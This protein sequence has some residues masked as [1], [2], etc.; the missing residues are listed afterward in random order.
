MAFEDAMTIISYASPYPVTL[1]IQ[2]LNSLKPALQTFRSSRR[3][4]SDRKAQFH[5][6]IKSQSSED[7][8]LN[9]NFY[10]MN[11]LERTSKSIHLSNTKTTQL[12]KEKTLTTVPPLEVVAE[13]REPL[14]KMLMKTL[15]ECNNSESSLESL[16]NTT[17]TRNVVVTA[18]ISQPPKFSN[19]MDIVI[20]PA[21]AKTKGKAPF[22]AT[23]DNE[24]SPE[25]EYNDLSYEEK[26]QVIRL[27]YE[28]PEKSQSTP[29]LSRPSSDTEEI[30][31][32]QN[33]FQDSHSKLACSKNLNL[34]IRK[35]NSPKKFTYATI[36]VNSNENHQSNLSNASSNENMSEFNKEQYE[37]LVYFQSQLAR[38][39]E[40]LAKLG[41]N[42]PIPTNN[43]TYAGKPDKRKINVG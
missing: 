3:Y 18:E 28:D 16:D 32:K 43:A 8:G 4:S 22:T 11:T 14:N 13:K 23:N 34:D 35:P 12:E 9:N 25:P 36:D 27:S 42:I 10:Q 15:S 21:R 33:Y 41:I 40:E 31:K 20:P 1:E 7:I 17:S 29:N 26:L 2:K 5:P 24:K 6:L 38:Q 19:Q 37:K 39:Q 30:V